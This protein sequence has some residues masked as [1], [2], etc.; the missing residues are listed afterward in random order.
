MITLKVATL[1]PGHSMS[2]QYLHESYTV[3][4]QLVITYYTNLT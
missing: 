4:E 1:D 3:K 2:Y